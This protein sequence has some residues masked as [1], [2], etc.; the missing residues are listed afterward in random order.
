MF[1]FLKKEVLGIT[2]RIIRRDFSGNTGVAIKNSILQFS[3]SIVSKLGSLA[4]N[5]I[6]AR[7]LLPE[8]YG[9]Y[10]LS[11]S[12]IVFFSSFGDMGIGSALITYLSRYK[13]NIKKAGAY[14]FFLRNLKIKLVLIV[15][16]ILMMSSYFIANVLYKKPIFYSLLAGGLY[17]V[18]SHLLAFVISLFQAQNNFKY[19]FY[20]EIF[21][22]TIRVILIPMTILFLITKGEEILIGGIF[23]ALS[24]CF[25]L[26]IF[27]IYP[28]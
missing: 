4:L 6:L 24:L 25:I 18:S 21:F 7:M 10:T 9:L 12:I 23:L 5:I 16:L 28:K 27:F 3:S 22:Q 20:K 1:N 8:T 14:L 17:I 13:D 15:A 26:S 19:P 11:L 2:K